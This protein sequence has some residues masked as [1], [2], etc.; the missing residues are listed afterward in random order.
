MSTLVDDIL[1]SILIC[2]GLKI[3]LW[4]IAASPVEMFV[5]FSWGVLYGHGRDVLIRQEISTYTAS[6][7]AQ[8]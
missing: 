2:L 4:Q 7:I 8:G 1:V 6:Q 5:P 3:H